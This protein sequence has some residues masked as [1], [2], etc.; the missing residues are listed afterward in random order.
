MGRKSR[1]FAQLH[2]SLEFWFAGLEAEPEK[3]S[4]L[5]PCSSLAT[6]L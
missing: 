2:L 6:I 3:V 4:G 1:R 5:E